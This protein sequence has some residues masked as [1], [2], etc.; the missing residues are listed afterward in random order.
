MYVS[1]WLYVHYWRVLCDCVADYFFRYRH[2]VLRFIVFVCFLRDTLFTFRT[3]R[4]TLANN[5]TNRNKREKRVVETTQCVLIVK[6]VC[7]FRRFSGRIFFLNLT[8][9]FIYPQVSSRFYV[10]QFSIRF[11]GTTLCGPP[12]RLIDPVDLPCMYDRLRNLLGHQYQLDLSRM[13]RL[14]VQREYNHL[15]SPNFGQ[16]TNFLSMDPSQ[17]RCKYSPVKYFANRIFFI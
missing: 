13:K 12:S 15:K 9:Y 8:G 4:K 5:R 16:E 11:Y 17:W 14:R 6:Y 10:F 2:R 7:N 1:K 3:K